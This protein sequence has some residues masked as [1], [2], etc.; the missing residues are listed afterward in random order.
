M[1]RKRI[2]TTDNGW[3]SVLASDA[4]NL[5]HRPPELEPGRVAAA[6]IVGEVESW[7]M[8]RGTPLSILGNAP[9]LAAVT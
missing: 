1:K 4:H 8:V 6:A 2:R 5:E 7:K 3:V 9:H